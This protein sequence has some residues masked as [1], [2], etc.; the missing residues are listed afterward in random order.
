MAANDTAY[1]RVLN[2]AH[3]GR[4]YVLSDLT[5]FDLGRGNGC[6]VRIDDE[7]CAF[8]HAR[9]YR[10]ESLWTFFDLN[11]EQGSKVNDIP[12]ER[13]ELEGGE[14]LLLGD[15]ELHFAFE[16]PV[17]KKMVPAVET[18]EK[19]GAPL[20]PQPPAPPVAAA[21]A[22]AKTPM[23]GDEPSS[24]MDFAAAILP[25]TPAAPAPPPPPVPAAPPI[26][27]SAQSAQSAQAAQAA[28]AAQVAQSAPTPAPAPRLGVATEST[29]MRIT[30]VDGDRRDIGKRVDMVGEGIATLGRALDC[31]IVLSDAKV[32]RRHSQ[33]TWSPL[34]ITIADLSS[35][36]GTVVNGEPATEVPLRKGDTVRL[37]FTLLTL[38]LI[39]APQE[40]PAVAPANEQA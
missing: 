31:D 12:V 35:V 13:R 34:G 1:L 20:S 39:A 9:I 21:P 15:T 7:A 37:G 23:V 30:V 40:A 38:E 11:T 27:Q 8:N 2:G 25:T 18:P 26:A 6:Q 19:T 3:K 16:A 4:V 32:S 5:V 17:S 36:N 10:K 28:Q 22:A 24:V 33:L 14:I 29:G